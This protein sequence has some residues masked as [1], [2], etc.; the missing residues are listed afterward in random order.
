[1]FSPSRGEDTTVAQE[2]ESPNE[3][4]SKPR[5]FI[6]ERNTPLTTSKQEKGTTSKD[7]FSWDSPTHQEPSRW[8]NIATQDSQR[9]SLN[10]PRG[11][12]TARSDNDDHTELPLGGDS[13]VDNNV[14]NNVD[15]NVGEGN[16][17]I[18]GNNPA[19]GNDD[20]EVENQDSGYGLPT[21]ELERR[22]NEYRLSN[23]KKG[24]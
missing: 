13:N 4:P 1:M 8:R 18:E 24:N 12:G 10:I 20:K 9:A 17:V 15:N 11:Q 2:K 14:E 19:E 21:E 23:R 16:N 7:P 22:Y 6:A 5:R 3:T